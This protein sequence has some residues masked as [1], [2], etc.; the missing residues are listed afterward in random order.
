M[1]RTSPEL[2]ATSTA[3]STSHNRQSSS[4]ST[5]SQGQPR[6]TSDIGGIGGVVGVVVNPTSPYPSLEPSPASPQ[7]PLRPLDNLRKH[8]IIK[9]S[10]GSTSSLMLH[11]SSPPSVDIKDIYNQFFSPILDP[12]IN[13]K[14]T[15]GAYFRTRPPHQND[16]KIA[17]IVLYD[18]EFRYLES[19]NKIQ[20]T[21]VDPLL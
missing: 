15:V 5:S 6:K 4:V 18:N 14:E 1:Y 9:M 12:S 7:Q 8:N 3:S 11:T 17:Y 21:N 19:R 2:I 10:Q 13:L 16:Q 20:L